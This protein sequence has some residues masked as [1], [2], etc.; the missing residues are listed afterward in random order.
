MN[1][2]LVGSGAL[3]AIYLLVSHATGAGTLISSTAS[4]ASKYAKTLQGR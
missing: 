3:I 4:G 1:R 2:F